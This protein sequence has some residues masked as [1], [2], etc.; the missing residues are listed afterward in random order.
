M[1]GFEK[2][3]A[4]LVFLVLSCFRVLIYRMIMELNLVFL[5]LLLS[6]LFSAVSLSYY[7]KIWTTHQATWL[8]CHWS[9]IAAE[10]FTDDHEPEIIISIRMH[11]E[12]I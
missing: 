7:K 11:K 9:I 4:L 5:S 2:N 8:L 10:S 12:C 1:L 6:K 3:I